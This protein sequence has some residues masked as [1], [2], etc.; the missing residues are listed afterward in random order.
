MNIV[1]KIYSFIQTRL[2]GFRT[3][4][5]RKICGNSGSLTLFGKVE[6]INPRNLTIGDGCTINHNCYLNCFN[7]V[8]IG[9]DVTLSAN[10]SIVSTGM[11]VTNWIKG[12]KCH[13]KNDGIEIGD[14]VWIGAGA[15][16]LSNVHIRGPYVVVAAGAVVTKD[17]DESYCIVGGCP[18]KVIKYL[19]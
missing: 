17:I 7:P 8:K 15:I 5:F 14:H 12:R 19:K 10:V 3:W 13:I 16:I 6:V 9:N 4:T 11:D 18:A 2:N 1:R